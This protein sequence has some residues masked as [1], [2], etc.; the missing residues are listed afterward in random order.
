MCFFIVQSNRTYGSNP[1]NKQE[2]MSTE[3]VDTQH[4]LQESSCIIWDLYMWVGERE[5]KRESAGNVIAI[6]KQ[7]LYHPDQL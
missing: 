5:K 7:N 6:S 1:K 4:T 2:T 3:L